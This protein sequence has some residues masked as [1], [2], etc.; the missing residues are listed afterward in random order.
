V[1][2]KKRVITSIKTELVDSNGNLAATLLDKSSIFL[3]ITR[4]NP[5]TPFRPK[6]PENLLLREQITN[7]DK[8]T[9]KS[10]KEEIDAYLGIQG[11]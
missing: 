3:K 9:K 11:D 10:Y 6:D 7:K 2:K 5:T 1:N 4:A 8:K